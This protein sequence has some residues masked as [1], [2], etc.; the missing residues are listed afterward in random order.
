MKKVTE[1]QKLFVQDTKGLRAVWVALTFA[2]LV[3]LLVVIVALFGVALDI[4]AVTFV[5]IVGGI[6]QF[7]ASMF[8]VLVFQKYAKHFT[9]I[10][11]AIVLASS[12]C[13][14]WWG[15]TQPFFTLLVMSFDTAQLQIL[16]I[17][18]MLELPIF[19]GILVALFALAITRPLAYLTN[20]KMLY[21]YTLLVPRIFG[22]GILF[23]VL[24]GY[25]LG[26]VAL[27]LYANFPLLE[28]TKLSILGFV[29]AIFVG[30]FLY[31]ASD[32]LMKPLRKQFELKRGIKPQI[33]R[34]YAARVFIMT[35]IISVGS[36]LFIGMAVLQS[37]Q[38][39][40]EQV[41]RDVLAD[42]VSQ[43]I[44]SAEHN[45]PVG[46]DILKVTDNTQIQ[47]IPRDAQYWNESYSQETVAFINTHISAST[48]D[49]QFR[50]SMVGFFTDPI[51]SEKIV[52]SI[53]LSDYNFLLIEGMR[54][55]GIAAITV[56]I[57]ATAITTYF[58]ATVARAIRSLSSAVRQARDSDT[59]FTFSTYTADE[60][61]DLALAFRY[62]INQA[63]ELRSHLEDKVRERTQALIAAEEEKRRLE[64]ESAQKT[65]RLEQQKREVAE[66]L[67][68]K[69]EEK[70]QER[71]AALRDAVRHLQEVDKVKS[72]FISL[73]SHQLRTP[74][75]G[76]KWA[77]EALLEDF[78]KRLSEKQR[79]V[80]GT[81]L[82]RI[83]YMTRLVNELL[84]VTKI[85]EEKYSLDLV[86]VNTA[87]WL[88]TIAG[89]FTDQAKR[90]GVTYKIELPK[91]LPALKIDREKL[92]M[93]IGN[94]IDNAIKYTQKGGTATLSAHKAGDN[95]AIV[96]KDT[97]IGI[98][99]KE[100][101]RAFSKFFRS[102]N[103]V[104]MHTSGSGLGMY[105]ARTIIEEHGG[106]ISLESQVGKGTTITCTIPLEVKEP[107]ETT[108]KRGTDLGSISSLT[109]S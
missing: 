55:F 38:T 43:F 92:A 21:A 53:P 6:T 35:I 63:N 96:V 65:T 97:G 109:D 100:Q 94:F 82:D 1:V 66:E 48:I 84:N 87:T 46:L 72:E 22:I 47:I 59:P 77:Q 69:L 105:I 68:E 102:E 42:R 10:T 106:A 3:S 104:E 51:R 45:Q 52:I 85:E 40:S 18:W 49:R 39:L 67:A 75:T 62:Y 16:T 90:S 91:T 23:L 11:K 31:F 93:A 34:S 50:K 24:L 27:R 36:L 88:G 7:L 86:A 108:T 107:T 14:I 4:S 70:V 15:V 29:S 57:F 58:S 8:F 5:Y 2:I 44:I 12:T 98:P 78:E 20:P 33:R 81:S 60:M 103:A 56:L 13:F 71:T 26:A 37:Y 95:I 73:A 19:A 25:V 74:L 89:Q 30:I 79:E 41:A 28:V 17:A 83:T 76:L 80:I 9:V 99:K 64:V 32:A 61:E 54:T 101:Y